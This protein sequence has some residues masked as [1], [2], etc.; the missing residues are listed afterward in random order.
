MPLPEPDV[1]LSWHPALRYQSLDPL[2]EGLYFLQRETFSS[3]RPSMI[4]IVVTDWA[5]EKRFSSEGYHPHF[6]GRYF[7][8]WMFVE[9]FQLSYVMCFE[10]FSTS[11][12]FTN[13]CQESPNKF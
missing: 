10:G 9:V 1:P 5:Q 6:P 7:A 11:T 3:R 12:P 8:S 13:F 2:L 4:G